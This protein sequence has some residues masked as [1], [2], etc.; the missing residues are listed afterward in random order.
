MHAI[1]RFFFEIRTAPGMPVLFTSDSV[2][3]IRFSCGTKKLQLELVSGAEVSI[4][5]YFEAYL[6][7]DNHVGFVFSV[8]TTNEDR[9]G[10][11]GL[12]WAEMLGRMYIIQPDTLTDFTLCVLCMYLE[13]I[14]KN[15]VS[16]S[17]CIMIKAAL[18]KIKRT[19]SFDAKVTALLVNGCEW[20]L[21]T[22]LFMHDLATFDQK[23]VLPHYSVAKPLMSVECEGLGELING[24]YYTQ[25]LFIINMPT[26][27]DGG[28]E[29]I[30][31]ARRSTLNKMYERGGVLFRVL[32]MWW[33]DPQKRRNAYAMYHVYNSK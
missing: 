5:D 32:S 23:L 9:I 24:L 13:N 12:T 30:A 31:E 19:I 14:P 10:T 29:V 18:D 21:N 4:D 8:I 15:E 25:S 6:E 22:L 2:E 26:K 16:M 28:I 27:A 1:P 7:M 11:L 3:G 20:L 33:N 17:H